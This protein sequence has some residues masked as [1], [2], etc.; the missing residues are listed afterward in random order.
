MILAETVLKYT[1][2]DLTKER[3]ILQGVAT[4]YVVIELKQG[5]VWNEIITAN[6]NHTYFKLY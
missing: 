4:R 6:A 5:K 3:K 2:S 1:S